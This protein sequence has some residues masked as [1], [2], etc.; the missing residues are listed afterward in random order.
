M[1]TEV[2]AE[3]GCLEGVIDL[4]GGLESFPLSC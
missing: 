4:V 2:L 1:F 3:L